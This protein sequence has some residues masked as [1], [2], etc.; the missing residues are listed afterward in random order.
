M[1]MILQLFH[2]G[3]KKQTSEE[4]DATVPLAF[5]S[6]QKVI[7]ELGTGRMIFGNMTRQLI[8]GHKKQTSEELN[9]IVLLVFQ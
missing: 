5:Q 4:L 3:L 7:L 1:E 9:A 6:E 8:F 2:P